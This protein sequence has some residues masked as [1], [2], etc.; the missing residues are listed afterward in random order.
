MTSF[1]NNT[2]M[3]LTSLTSQITDE[4]DLYFLYTLDIGE[5]DFHNLKK[6]QHILV[7]FSGFAAKFVDLVNMCFKQRESELMASHFLAN[8]DLDSGIFSIIETNEFKH[9]TH[10]SLRFRPGNDAAVKSY[11]AS[12]LIQSQTT[13]RE[14]HNE[15][16]RCQ[17]LISRL[18]SDRE[19][20][21]EELV[22]IRYN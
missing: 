6:E 15:L 14:Q 20:L 10:L 18:E 12:T 8:L 22:S 13:C 11:L 1:T 7:D 5:H 17:L 2:F 19:T 21:S 16:Q 4:N 3:Y 9:L